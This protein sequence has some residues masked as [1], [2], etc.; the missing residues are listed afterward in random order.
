MKDKDKA[1]PKKKEKT[2]GRKPG[3]P[4][5]V[6]QEVRSMLQKHG[7]ELVR[8]LM[9][10]SRCGNK[11]IAL[12]ATAEALNRAYGKPPVMV[13]QNPMQPFDDEL[14]PHME[15]ARRV[16]FMAHLEVEAGVIE[17]PELARMHRSEL[18]T[19]VVDELFKAWRVHA[20]A[21]PANAEPPV[22]PTALE[23]PAKPEAAAPQTTEEPGGNVVTLKRRPEENQK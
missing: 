9:S 18:V 6:T 21:P 16:V 20:A 23:E 11:E 8:K 7:V 19:N 14:T 17:Y 13:E 3:T 22:A 15:V 1:K 2:G 10:L 4:N 12:R 5:K